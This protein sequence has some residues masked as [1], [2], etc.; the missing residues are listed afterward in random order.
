[1]LIDSVNLQ[2]SNNLQNSGVSKLLNR[3]HI[4]DKYKRNGTLCT[5]K[6]GVIYAAFY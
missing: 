4:I 6:H 2:F 5:K 3:K 1:M